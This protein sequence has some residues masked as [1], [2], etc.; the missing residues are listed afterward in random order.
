MITSKHHTNT[1]TCTYLSFLS[2]VWFQ[3]RRMKDKRQ[4]MAIPWALFGD[5]YLTAVAAV[6]ARNHV[7]YPQP[8]ALQHAHWTLPIQ[9]NSAALAA[10]LSAAHTHRL[11]PPGV[12]SH[13][14]NIPAHAHLMGEPH[15]SALH[16]P[17]L[18]SFL[19]QHQYLQ[20][21][22][23][24]SHSTDEDASLRHVNTWHNSDVSRLE[25]SSAN[26]D[27]PTEVCDV[28]DDVRCE[29]DVTHDSDGEPTTK[30]RKT[31]FRP[32]EVGNSD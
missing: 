21:V 15:A 31:F 17:P 23:A 24:R 7:S 26:S 22:F 19:H 30:R 27:K 29:N 32:F 13:A 9:K 28:T 25:E 11:T 4:K 5:P 16:R 20:R 8:P 3:N 18:P 2:Q 1:C 14:L 6:A 10:H 12:A